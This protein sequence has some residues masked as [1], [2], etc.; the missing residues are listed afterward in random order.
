M[1][2]RWREGIKGFY[3]NYNKEGKYFSFIRLTVVDIRKL[4]LYY[5]YGFCEVCG[6]CSKVL[7]SFLAYYGILS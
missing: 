6:F 5:L 3:Y 1:G 2:I 7:G 4:V